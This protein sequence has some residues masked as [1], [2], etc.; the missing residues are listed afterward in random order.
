MNFL[1]G[2]KSYIGAA[3]GVIVGVL[4]GLGII[5][6]EMAGVGL[7]IATGIFGA[8][9]AGKAQKIANA[10]SETLTTKE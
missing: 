6:Q 7:T 8:G 3:L 5:D 4:A 10:L 2:Y 1:D 9:M